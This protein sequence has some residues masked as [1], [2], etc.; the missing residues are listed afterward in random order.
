M[1]AEFVAYMAVAPPVFYFLSTYKKG[2][3][4]CCFEAAP[5]GEFMK[6]TLG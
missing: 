5:V 4:C 6:G 1:L 3:C 2:E